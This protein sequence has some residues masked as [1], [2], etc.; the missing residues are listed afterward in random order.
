MRNRYQDAGMSV[1]F[2]NEGDQTNLQASKIRIL[3][4]DDG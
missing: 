1:D 4:E 2:V 3:G